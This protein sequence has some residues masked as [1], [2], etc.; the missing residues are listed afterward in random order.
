MSRDDDAPL[1][2]APSPSKIRAEHNISLVDHTISRAHSYL[3]DDHAEQSDSDT[4]TAT[5]SSA[6]PGLYHRLTNNSLRQT[7]RQE[8]TKQK[9]AKFGQDRYH[10]DE[11]SQPSLHEDSA[12]APQRGQ[13]ATVAQKS[14]L[15]RAQT[16]ARALMNRKRTL[17]KGD[18][19][20]TIVDVLYENQ[21]GIFFF[22]I[23]KYSSAS[24]L[25]T[26][27]KPWQNG[28][29][30]TSAVDIRNAQ[31]PDPS[32]EW[33]WKSWYVDMS[34]D[35]DE[36]GWEYSFAFVGKA[37]ATFAWHGNHP[38]FHSFVRRRRWLRMRKRK[39]QKHHTREK[40]HE[41]TTDYFTIH[42]KTVRAGSLVD[43]QFGPNT[44]LQLAKLRD[45]VLD[46]GNTEISSI[47]DLFLALRKSNVDREKIQAVKKFIDEGGE[48]LYYLSDRMGDIMGTFMFQSSRRQLLADL[49]S[50]HE[51]SHESQR[52]L[53]SHRHEGDDAKQQEHDRAAR[54]A[55]N[56][57]KAVHAADEQVKKLEYWSDIRDLSNAAA[58]VDH[59]EGHN[60]P[61]FKSKQKAQDGVPNING[62]PDR[63]GNLGDKGNEIAYNTE[64]TKPS[65]N[66]T[67]F[68]NSRFDNMQHTETGVEDDSDDEDDEL[69]RYTTASEQFPESSSKKAKKG[70]GQGAGKGKSKVKS[71]DGV[72]EAAE[73][74]QQDFEQDPLISATTGQR[75][76]G[77]SVQV[78][79]PVPE[80]S[81]FRP[82]GDDH[83][84]AAG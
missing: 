35:V 67:N 10:V 70:K 71:L 4:A 59:D 15:E 29:F 32:W 37:G 16:R 53:A 84:G 44:L 66:G 54:W 76:H 5:P 20:D 11:S 33:A 24:L 81:D 62:Q 82:L 31:V 1:F 61:S 34:R 6:P 3:R 80:P 64:S 79:E 13:V 48:E 58:V 60:E 25:P 23:P 55:D 39:S 42:P 49:I 73:E 26:D 45:P 65:K 63:P 14:Y 47:G 17:G 41:L 2:R 56:L 69:E 36:E 12:K 18:A 72:H 30:R 21:R 50:R 83:G 75:D 19:E 9:Y 28:Q 40:A 74:H 38:W 68:V 7:V 27:P 43:S 78:V 8:Y 52:D 77:T 46:L 22:G 57:M 51:E